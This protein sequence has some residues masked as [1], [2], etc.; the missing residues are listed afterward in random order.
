MELALPAADV[1]ACAPPPPG[2]TIGVSREGRPLVGHRFGSGARH[3][4][5]IAGCHADEPVGPAMLD[6]LGGFLHGLDADHPLLSRL[7]WWLVPHVNPDGEERN[8][9]W[10][11]ATT[12]DAEGRTVYDLARYV[13]GA[14]RERPGDDVEFG[15]PRREDDAEARPENRAMA[16]FLRGGAPF[17]L[18]GSFHGMAFAAGPWF[19]IEA[20]WAGRTV[21]M[22]RRLRERT[23]ALG[24]R[25]HDVDRRGDKGFHRI[26]EGFTTRPD[27]RAMRAWF[28][29]RGDAE[30]A[31]RFRPSSMEY[32]RSLGGDPLTLV[33]EMPLFLLPEKHY[34]EGDVVRPPVLERL[35][36]AADAASL[37]REARA[38]GVAAMPIDDQMRLQL[39]FLD[40]ALAAALR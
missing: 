37:E 31:R 8:A 6:R 2:E 10:T 22:R 19:L 27:S 36:A 13:A 16:S 18:H 35:Q 28:E 25:V 30:T 7:A 39:A 3:V 5:L 11:R 4:S 33:S 17:V 34:R 12:T 21:A 29:R 9:A 20:S 26:D 38:V 24:Y 32:V 15:F 14:V 40:E 1:L 23:T